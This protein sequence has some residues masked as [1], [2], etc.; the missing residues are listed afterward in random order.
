MYFE[1]RSYFVVTAT[2]LRCVYTVNPWCGRWYWT[3]NA[4]FKSTGTSL[5]HRYQWPF[6]FCQALSVIQGSAVWVT[7]WPDGCM[8]CGAR[9]CSKEVLPC[10][11][12]ANTCRGYVNETPPAEV[13]AE[14]PA[15][16]EHH[17][18][19]SAKKQRFRGWTSSQFTAVLN[20]YRL[21][22][23]VQ[24]TRHMMDCRNGYRSLDVVTDYYTITYLWNIDASHCKFAR[25][26]VYVWVCVCASVCV[27][28][29]ML[30]GLFR[31]AS[32]RGTCI[33]QGNV[34]STWCAWISLVNM[35]CSDSEIF[36]CQ[37]CQ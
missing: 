12:G 27:Y 20:S 33:A 10:N 14:P 7:W 34:S 35:L 4:L 19:Q 18:Q 32:L 26:S 1:T 28:V 9:F 25:L 11:C 6:L 31:S 2:G 24:I 17:R 29:W 22:D 37:H 30:G 21:L 16:F 3:S 15:A 36:L 5:P 13:A 23:I 8:V